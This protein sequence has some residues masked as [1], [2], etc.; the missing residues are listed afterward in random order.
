M[1]NTNCAVLSA[2]D[3][4]TRTG[5]KVDANQLVSASFHLSYSDGTA[6]GS[7]KIQASNDV[8]GYGNVA[9]AFT[10]TNW[11]DVPSATATV[12]AG[13]Q[14]LVTIANMSYRWV[15]VIWTQTTPGIGTV[16]CNMNALSI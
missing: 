2:L 15:R 10:P 8:C 14:G 16:T 5:G 7:F 3:D 9:A 6:A 11:V 1:R 12:A 4:V 13:A